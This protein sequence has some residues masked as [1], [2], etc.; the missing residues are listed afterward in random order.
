[1]NT[2]GPDSP[3]YSALIDHLDRLNR[4]KEQSG[5]RPSPDAMAVVAGNL[6]GILIIVAYEQKHVM[7]SKGLGFVLKPKESRI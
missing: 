5:R 1:M 2:Y 4:M 3:E 6:L 7:V